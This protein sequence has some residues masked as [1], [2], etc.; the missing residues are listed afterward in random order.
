MGEDFFSCVIVT[1]AEE[2][3]PCGV[4]GKVRL[5]VFKLLD[6]AGAEGLSVLDFDIFDRN[7]LCGAACVN[8]SSHRSLLLVAL[9]RMVD[10]IKLLTI[11]E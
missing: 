6:D 7:G 4:I 1:L 11:K 3:D 5:M 9:A 2:S 10:T 8:A